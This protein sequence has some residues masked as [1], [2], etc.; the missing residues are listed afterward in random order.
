MGKT[1]EM[2]TEAE[3]RGHLRLLRDSGVTN[4]WGAGAYLM[5][6]MGLSR[7]QAR[8]YVLRWMRSTEIG[9]LAPPS[10]EARRGPEERNHA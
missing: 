10:D 2:P 6:D 4:M 5:R 3:V 9:K 7:A 1:K 8:E